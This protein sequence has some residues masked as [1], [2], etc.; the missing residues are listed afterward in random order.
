MSPWIHRAHALIERLSGPAKDVARAQ[1]YA[2]ARACEI[3]DLKPSDIEENGF[4]CINARKG[5]SSRTCY[6]PHLVPY[7]RRAIALETQRV[8]AGFTYGKYRA[9]LLNAADGVIPS[10]GEHYIFSNTFRRAAAELARGLAKGDVRVAQY[11]L[12]HKSL[13]STQY[14]LTKKG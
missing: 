4:V 8:F 11:T 10:T 13:R 1:L 7:R 12:G 6:L 14:Y 5:S 3:L 2:A 9:A